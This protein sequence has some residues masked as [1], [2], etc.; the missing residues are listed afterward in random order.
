MLRVG[1]PRWSLLVA[2]PTDQHSDPFVNL[3]RSVAFCGEVSYEYP[4]DQWE[5]LPPPFRPFFLLTYPG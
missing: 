5:F 4:S 2:F 1:V 3:R